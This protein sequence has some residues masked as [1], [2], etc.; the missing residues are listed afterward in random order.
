MARFG[1]ISA[2]EDATI[3]RPNLEC[4]AKLIH[5]ESGIVLT[6]EKSA[7]VR[8]RLLRRLKATGIDNFTDYCT[9]VQ[10]VAGFEE[11][12]KMLQALT[13]NMTRFYRE[14]HHFEDFRDNVIPKL[15]ARA[16]KG[17][18]VRIW[19]SA[20]STGEEP[21]SIAFELLKALP[22]AAKYDIKVLATDIDHTVVSRARDGVY[23]ARLVADLDSNVLSQNFTQEQS[24]IEKRYRVCDHVRQ[25]V[26]FKELNLIKPWP[27]NGPFDVIFCR[28]VLIYFDRDTQEMLLERFSKILGPGGTLY[29]GHSERMLGI[30]AYRFTNA[31]MTTFR[32]SK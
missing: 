9:F 1:A 25:I 6:D 26:Y 17:D 7:L 21:Y 29:L 10:T 14:Y 2:L 27:V 3:S 23:P 11:R 32:L 4:I 8:S 24:G 5:D 20:C 12:R 16:R 18:R 19:S 15:A 28:N 31:G 13:T 30:A 22:E